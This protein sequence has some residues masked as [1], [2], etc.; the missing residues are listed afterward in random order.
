MSEWVWV[1]LAVVFVIVESI[2]LGLTTIWFAIGALL[3]FLMAFF[4]YTWQVQI[5]VFLGSSLVMLYY[6]A[7]FARRYLKIGTT[8]TNVQALIGESAL[9]IETIQHVK[10]GQVQVKGQIWRAK[11]VSKDEVIEVNEEVVIENIDGNTLVVRK[12][13]EENSQEEAAKEE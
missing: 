3:A 4:E 7:P 11:T 13:K 1:A 9:V 10:Y 12:A 8:P 6:T 5:I 2:T